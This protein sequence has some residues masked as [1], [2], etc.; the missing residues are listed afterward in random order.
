MTS[1]PVT[2]ELLRRMLAQSE[3]RMQAMQREQELQSQ[4]IALLNKTEPAQ[5][6]IEA[7][8]AKKRK[9]ESPEPDPQPKPKIN[10]SAVWNLFSRCMTT[11]LGRD[12]SVSMPVVSRLYGELDKPT[13]DFF[14]RHAGE[15][16]S[17]PGD[18]KLALVQRLLN[19]RTVGR[20]REVVAIETASEST[21]GSSSDE[22]SSESS[23][24][25]ESSASSEFSGVS[26]SYEGNGEST[27]DESDASPRDSSES[28]ESAEI[29]DTLRTDV[30]K[31][32]ADDPAPFTERIMGDLLG[33]VSSRVGWRDSAGFLAVLS[34][35]T[36]AWRRIEFVERE[37]LDQC[38][39]CSEA[40]GRLFALAIGLRQAELLVACETCRRHIELCVDIRD[41]WVSAASSS[42]FLETQ[43]MRKRAVESLCRR[44][45]KLEVEADALLVPPPDLSP[46]LN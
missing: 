6:Q 1:A 34:G 43:L 33:R 31:F 9:L 37:G 17:L 4:L 24:S 15:M 42:M 22:A 26:Y 16:A 2:D 35:S 46:G 5:P 14:I 19:S 21:G 25:G 12:L 41:F 7:A 8:P 44:F 29:S 10:G 18:K 45:V 3:E 23:A 20:I 27:P 32:I 39:L 40:T 30:E 13:K 36:A 38:G 28:S 11:N